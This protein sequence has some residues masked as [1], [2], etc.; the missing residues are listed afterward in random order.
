MSSRMPWHGVV[1]ATALPFR[2]DLSVDLDAYAE[3]VRGLSTPAATA[4]CPNG[5]LGEYQTLTDDERAEV[6]AHRR[7]GRRRR[8]GRCRAWRVRLD[9]VA[10]LGRAGGRGRR[11]RR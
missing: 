5:S 1:V 9:G 10:A 8:P 6:V 4:S 11:R 3:H 7:R 2:D